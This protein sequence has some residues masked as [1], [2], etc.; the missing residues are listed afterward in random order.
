MTVMVGTPRGQSH[1]NTDGSLRRDRGA[2]RGQHKERSMSAIIL[3]L[4]PPFPFVGL[5]QFFNAFPMC[6]LER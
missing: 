5:S 4:E 2:A 1:N 3:L 6:E